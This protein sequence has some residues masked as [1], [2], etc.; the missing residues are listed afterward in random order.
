MIDLGTFWFDLALIVGV[1]ALLGW[2]ALPSW[3][4]GGGPGELR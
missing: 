4:P 1:L 3:L 2:R